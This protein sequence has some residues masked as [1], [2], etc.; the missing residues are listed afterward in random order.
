[1]LRPLHPSAGPD[2]QQRTESDLC[3]ELRDR[4][5]ITCGHGIAGIL[6]ALEQEDPVGLCQGI[7][8]RSA[9]LEATQSEASLQDGPF[10]DLVVDFQPLVDEAGGGLC[11]GNQVLGGVAKDRLQA[12]GDVIVAE[13]IAG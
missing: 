3:E 13:E 2:F 10:L 7:D 9:E 5:A 12:V 4:T 8:G 6:E 11:L 1:M